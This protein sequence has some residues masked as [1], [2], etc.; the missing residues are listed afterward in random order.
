MIGSGARARLRRARPLKFAREIKTPTGRQVVIGA[1]QRL[2]LGED[3]RTF[4]SVQPEFT[5]IDI[6]L[7][8]DGKGVGKVAP[9]AQVTYNK[10]TK[11]LEI[12]NFGAQP[13]R[14][15]DVRSEHK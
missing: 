14:L 15:K 8:P 3:P 12:E 10:Q 13:V 5:L 1:D 11:A 9:A 7:G 6:R 4:R 2:G